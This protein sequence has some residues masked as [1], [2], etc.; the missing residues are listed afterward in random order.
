MS[1]RQAYEAELQERQR[2]H[3]ASLNP[4][5]EANWRPCLHEQCP[6]CHGTGLSAH[7]PCIHG[8]SCNCPKHSFIC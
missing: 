7:G 6:R 5:Q 3:L 8:I 1:T 4:T 2:Q